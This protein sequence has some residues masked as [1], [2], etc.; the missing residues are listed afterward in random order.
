MGKKQAEIDG[1][2][3]QLAEAQTHGR[4][5]QELLVQAKQEFDQKSR[6]LSTLRNEGGE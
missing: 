3:A 2:R 1:L 6:I 4:A 5:L